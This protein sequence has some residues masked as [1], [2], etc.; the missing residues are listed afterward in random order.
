[1]EGAKPLSTEGVRGMSWIG[2][3]PGR[4]YAGLPGSGYVVSGLVVGAAV[5]LTPLYAAGAAFNLWVG[6]W[7]LVVIPA[8]FGLSHVLAPRKAWGGKPYWGLTA[9][10][11]GAAMLSL[12][13]RWTT[14]DPYTPWLSLFGCVLFVAAWTLD[15][16]SSAFA[17]PLFRAQPDPRLRR[18]STRALSLAN[19][20]LTLLLAGY[21]AYLTPW[22]LALTPRQPHATTRRLATSLGGSQGIERAAWS[23]DGRYLLLESGEWGRRGGLWLLEVAGG[24]LTQV[25]AEGK[26]LGDQPWRAGEE[27]FVYARKDNQDGLWAASPQRRPHL[28]GTG[29]WR[30][31]TVSPDG[32]LIAFSRTGGV[33]L[34]QSDASRPRLVAAHCH[35]PRWSPDGKHLLVWRAIRDPKADRSRPADQSLAIADLTGKVRPLPLTAEAPPTAAWLDAGHVV[36]LGDVPSRRPLELLPAGTMVL[37]TWD[38]QGRRVRNRRIRSSL[39]LSPSALAA[40]PDGRYLALTLG[41]S[42]PASP[43]W[44]LYLLDSATGSLRALPTG[45]A[46][47]QAMWSPDGARLACIGTDEVRTDEAL[48]RPYLGVVE[49]L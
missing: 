9:L 20:L 26:V 13:A 45:A 24:K 33:W 36:T 38:V 19:A 32:R 41:S 29:P 5:C 3:L 8:L 31:P 1:M 49:G 23:R 34:A 47:W 15:D 18:P 10:W 7:V 46:V 11:L 21:V 37:E 14:L 30:T 40:A 2:S 22:E 6:W 48:P 44:A 16:L 35:S 39:I 17:R 25:D 42:F 4:L 12:L 43:K 27:G 28:V